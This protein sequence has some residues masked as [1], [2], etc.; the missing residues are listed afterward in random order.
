M[1]TNLRRIAAD[2]CP[3]SESDLI[4]YFMDGCK[5]REEW[6][7][8]AEFEK[9]ALDRATGRQIGFD[10]GVESQLCQLATQC[11]WEAHE[12]AGRVTT[13]TRGGST[14]S[15][16]PGG[17]VELSTPPAAHLAELQS[18]LN[19]HIAEL[20]TVTDPARVA[21][22][23][24]G[25]S[26]FSAIEDIALN[27]RPRH[28]LMA[29]YLPRRCEFGLHMMKATASTQV[30]FDYA[31]EADA[32]RK[33]AVALCLS[34]LVNAAFANAPLYAGK[35][36]GLV[37]FRGRIWQGMDPDRSGFLAELLTGE[38]TFERWAGFVLDVPL[39]FVEVDGNLHTAPCISFRDWMNHGLDG[40]FPTLHD[41]ELHISTVFTEARMKRFIE[42]RGADANPTPIALAVPAV[43]KGLLYDA[44]A[45][46][47]AVELSSQFPP[48][49]LLRLSDAA[50]RLGLRAEHRGKTLAMWCREL[51]AIAGTGLLRGNHPVEAAF[52][53]PLSEV[54]ASGRSPGELW[55]TGGGVAA[56]LRACEYPI[57]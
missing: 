53:D 47:A 19:R 16:E 52:L 25:V 10:A 12:E 14:I 57:T 51:L 26:P 32:G 24:A 17:Q 7:V 41:W 37:S 2:D 9:F 40:R 5:P 49:E 33:F 48:G 46:A 23:A 3:V 11:G 20:R 50:A 6:R 44:G 42:V 54:V 28:R 4:A 39:L 30:T 36:T 21:W 35:P 8:G 1:S 18:E 22:V 29:E 13:L 56:V 43:W 27:P 34:P 45:L 15:V 38:V 55:P 31:D